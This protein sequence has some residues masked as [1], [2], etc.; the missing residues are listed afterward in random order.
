MVRKGGLPPLV[1]KDETAIR[2]CL[3][4]DP[5]SFPLLKLTDTNS[6]D[7]IRLHLPSLDVGHALFKSGRVCFV[8]FAALNS[9]LRDG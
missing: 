9:L 2:L 4:W 5:P 6:N 8:S 7:A 3:L 1:G